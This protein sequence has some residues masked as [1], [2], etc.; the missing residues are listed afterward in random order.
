[1]GL[2]ATGKFETIH[3]IELPEST[4]HLTSHLLP[5]FRGAVE[6]AYLPDMLE[7]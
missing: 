7:F 6:D 2:I 1:L 3:P 5:T 4:F